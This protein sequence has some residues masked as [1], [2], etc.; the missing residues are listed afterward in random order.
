MVL[1]IAFPGVNYDEARVVGFC[2]GGWEMVFDGRFG[3]SSRA[4]LFGDEACGGEAG[5]PV[6]QAARRLK[7]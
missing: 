3:E 2:D 4:P 5:L 6:R 7:V 1:I